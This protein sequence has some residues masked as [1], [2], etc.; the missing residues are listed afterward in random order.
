LSIFTANFKV[1]LELPPKR[2]I[3]D[4]GEPLVVRPTLMGMR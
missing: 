2:S 3:F 4:P 1:E